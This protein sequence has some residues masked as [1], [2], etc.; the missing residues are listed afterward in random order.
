MK[1]LARSGVRSGSYFSTPTR[2]GSPGGVSVDGN[3]SV[4]SDVSSFDVSIQ[5]QGGQ[6]FTGAQ[7]GWQPPVRPAPVQPCKPDELAGL[8][9]EERAAVIKER[10]LAALALPRW[11]SSKVYTDGMSAST[12][13]KVVKRARNTPGVGDYDDDVSFRAITASGTSTTRRQPPGSP[14]SS[15]D[16][17]MTSSLGA[18]AASGPRWR[19]AGKETLERSLTPGPAHYHTSIDLSLDGIADRSGRSR[20]STSRSGKSR[21]SPEPARSKGIKTDIE[22]LCERAAASPGPADY[23]RPALPDPTGGGRFN[24]SMSKSDIEWYEI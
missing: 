17:S 6:P 18:M 14:I 23:G 22:M 13:E 15:M 24:K 5:S 1:F 19:Q 11:L 2:A 9:K 10:A 12:M 21:S 3:G 4:F 7:L 8:S 16:G 20:S